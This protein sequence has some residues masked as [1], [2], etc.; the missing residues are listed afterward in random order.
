MSFEKRNY[1][2]EQTV[3][4]AKN[5][6]DIQDELIRQAGEN[7]TPIATAEIPGKV[8]PGSNL[9]VAADGTLN[10]ADGVIPTEETVSGW[11]FTKNSGTYS[12]PAGGIPKTDLASVVQASLGKADSAVQPSQAVT[13]T[14]TLEDGSTKTY[15]LYG[16]EATSNES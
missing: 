8:K 4:T 10:F 2:S 7:Y 5:L 15:T 3:I 6:N 11:G 12:K 1:I 13:M 9:S 14:A 16:Y